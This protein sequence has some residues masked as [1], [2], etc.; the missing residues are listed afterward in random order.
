M[1]VCICHRVSDRDIE[2][3][4]RQGCA[5]FDA[6]QRQLRVASACGA[7]GDCARKVFGKACAGVGAATARAPMHFVSLQASAAA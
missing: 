6:L 3:E 7:C 2:R 1:I 5:S 4:V